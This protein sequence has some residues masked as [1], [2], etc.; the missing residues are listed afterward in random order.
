M[1][2]S[3]RGQKVKSRLSII[4]YLWQLPQNLLGLALVCLTHAKAME[5]K[6]GIT[7]YSTSGMK[8]TGVSLGSMVIISENMFS[9]EYMRKHEYG[10]C[11]QS[12]MLGFMYL[13]IVGIPSIAMLFMSRYSRRRC[14]PGKGRGRFAENY[15]IMQAF[16]RILSLIS[17][18]RSMNTSYRKD[19]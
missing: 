10:H 2:G 12:K 6:D 15:F 7:F 17:F 4:L 13:I 8:G 5:T 3:I 18:M 9:R 1:A 14:L 16:T 11:R 19:P